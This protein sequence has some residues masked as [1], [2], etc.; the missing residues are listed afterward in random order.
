MGSFSKWSK[1]GCELFKKGF[2]SL[3]ESKTKDGISQ[4]VLKKRCQWAKAS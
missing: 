3:G 4:S 1:I 2:T